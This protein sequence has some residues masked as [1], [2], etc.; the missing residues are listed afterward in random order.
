MILKM[1]RVIAPLKEEMMSWDRKKKENMNNKNGIDC[2]NMNTNND[3]KIKDI[4]SNKNK[5]RD[6][7]SI[8]NKDTNSNN[9][10]NK[11]NYNNSK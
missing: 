10:N 11:N 7:N 3:N 1:P 2:S 4:N 5:N 6:I 9:I 8:I